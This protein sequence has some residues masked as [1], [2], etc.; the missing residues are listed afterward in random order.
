MYVQSSRYDMCICYEH[1]KKEYVCVNKFNSKLKFN[2]NM[3]ITIY[4]KL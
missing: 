3:F 4:R 2:G 1:I